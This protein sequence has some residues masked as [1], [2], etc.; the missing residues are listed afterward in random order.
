MIRNLWL[1]SAVAYLPSPLDVPAIEGFDESGE[2]D[3]LGEA[4]SIALGRRGMNL[5]MI[6]HQEENVF[7]KLPSCC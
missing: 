1:D 3:G 6:D 2:A 7:L 4:W 5:L